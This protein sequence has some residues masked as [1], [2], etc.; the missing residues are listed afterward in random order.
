MR[1]MRLEQTRSGGQGL[2]RSCR[3]T[4][5]WIT[6]ARPAAGV[7][8]FRAWLVGEAYDRHRHD[9]YAIGLTDAG[10]QVFDYRGAA[11]ASTPGKVVVLHPDE[12]H[13]GRAGTPAGFSYRIVYVEPAVLGEALR[14]VR[15]R[16]QPLPFVRD[17]VSRSPALAR[18]V[19]EAFA[20]PLN[21]LAADAV[22]VALAEGLLGAARE[23]T[24]AAGRCVDGRAVQRARELLDA[25]P[26]RAVTSQELEAATGLSRYD[27]ARQ[28]RIALGTSPHRYLVLRR[29]DLARARLRTSER[30][31]EIAAEAG[32]ADQPH[33]TR[34]FRS[35]FGLTPGRY[36]TL[37]GYTTSSV[38]AVVSPKRPSAKLGRPA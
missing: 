6:S 13:D 14:A 23:S 17:P 27:L 3:P 10:V 20:G 37:L 7:E 29:L 9:T 30:L 25:A 12:A 8:L 15:G 38:R 24:L 5:S 21:V 16:A 22:V 4:G 35:A 11:R 2:E 34:A 26:E 33:F 28:F 18:A 32:F 36:R 31:A 19:S 1:V